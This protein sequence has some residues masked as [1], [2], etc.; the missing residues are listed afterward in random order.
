MYDKFFNVNV[1]EVIEREFQGDKIYFKRPTLDQRLKFQ[2]YCANKD[3]LQGT[4]FALTSILVN[5]KGKAVF[6]LSDNKLQSIDPKFLDF[7]A[8][9]F[10]ELSGMDTGENENFS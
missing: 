5:A 6:Q 10:L 7:C 3:T 9:A 1:E 8:S 2:N 4:K